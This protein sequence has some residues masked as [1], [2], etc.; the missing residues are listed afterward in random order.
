MSSSAVDYICF[1]YM[2]FSTEGVRGHYCATPLSA[3]SCRRLCP[4]FGGTGTPARRARL[5]SVSQQSKPCEARARRS[6][7]SKKVEHKTKGFKVSHL[8]HLPHF[9]LL[10]DSE[11]IHLPC[12]YMLTIF[13]ARTS[14]AARR[15]AQSSNYFQVPQ[16]ARMATLGAPTRKHKVTIIGSGN[17]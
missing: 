16:R 3:A 15:S 14:Q 13:T 7:K 1:S 4:S 12:N 17:W 8:S 6:H 10:C 11:L 9:S 5:S 2:L